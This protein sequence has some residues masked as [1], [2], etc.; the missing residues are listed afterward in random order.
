MAKERKPYTA[1]LIATLFFISVVAALMLMPHALKRR[2]Q[3]G[4]IGSLLP[5]PTEAEA[6]DVNSWAQAVRK[7]KEDRG[8]PTGKDAKVETPQQLRLYNDKRRFLAV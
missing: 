5:A 2:A 6:A 1:L 3:S 8:E 4:F 7:V